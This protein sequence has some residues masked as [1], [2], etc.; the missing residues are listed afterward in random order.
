MFLCRIIF[1]KLHESPRYLVHAG[2]K[3]EAA[4]A[5]TEIA[6]FNGQDLEFELDDVDDTAEVETTL[7]R[8]VSTTRHSI[9]GQPLLPTAASPV[10]ATANGGAEGLPP[11]RPRLGG[12]GHGHSRSRSGMPAIR[13]SSTASV[14]SL[15]GRKGSG[16]LRSLPRWLR[17]P[18]SMWMSRVEP[19]FED[20]WRERT[21]LIWGVWGCLALGMCT[22][23]SAVG[24]ISGTYCCLAAYT[25][26]NV[27]LPKL[28][29][30]RSRTP[31]P[32]SQDPTGNSPQGN[33]DL[34]GPLW[35]V[36]L[37]TL[38]GCP[39]ALV[40]LELFAN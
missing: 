37:F 13:R 36:V 3:E 26:F 20:D 1:F 10:S 40:C 17:K 29:E 11:R 19:L 24:P 32:P 5:L 35:E 33:N 16:F 31:R 4:V 25:M 12:P 23:A 14:Y 8:E 39:G 22:I 2:R 30:Y 34:E 6:K 27:Y 9:E 18:I 28:L 15:G 21:L 38:G 7:Q